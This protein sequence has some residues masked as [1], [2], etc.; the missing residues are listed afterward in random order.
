MA[1][2]VSF[3]DT[4]K[5]QDF[6]GNPSLNQLP[7]NTAC[8][9]SGTGTDHLVY[10]NIVKGRLGNNYYLLALLFKKKKKFTSF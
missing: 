4:S 10:H 3:C 2:T 7:K 5:S 9:A 8:F 6:K 1:V